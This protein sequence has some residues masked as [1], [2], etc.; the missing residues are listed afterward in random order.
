[1]KAAGFL[2]GNVTG[3]AWP[4]ARGGRGQPFARR[5]A[6][7]AVAALFFIFGAIVICDS[8]R[9]GVGWRR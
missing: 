6:E 3:R 4:Q 8:A 9:L 2:A 7:L 1:M 5:R